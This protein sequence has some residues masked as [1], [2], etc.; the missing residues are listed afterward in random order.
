MSVAAVARRL[1]T[2]V[3]R[4]GFRAHYR[5]ADVTYAVGVA[6]P[7]RTVAGM[8][9]SYEPTNPHSDDVG[10][11]ALDDL[12]TDAAVYDVGAHVGEYAI[13][14]VVGTDRRIVAFEPN[15]ES[16]DR[17][18]RNVARNGVADRIDTHR[19]GLGAT[20]ET[21]TFY[22]STFS[23]L[24]SFDQNAASRWGAS[25]AGT[26]HVPVHRLDDLTD[27]LPP[28]DGMK[29][30]VEGDELAVLRGA[31]KTVETHRPLIVVERHESVDDGGSE[32]LGRWFD[33]RTYDVE[34]H[35]DTWVCRG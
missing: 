8:Y 22:R 19:T 16:A 9:W 27:D 23:K 12:S 26:T 25:V 29:I 4:F 24:S 5:L 7:K 20:D 14:L 15:G 13:P 10:L 17:F 11:A 35:D 34:P 2:H 33:D 3:E 1:R 28:P 21:R 6:T 31:T 18:E 30:D 32:T